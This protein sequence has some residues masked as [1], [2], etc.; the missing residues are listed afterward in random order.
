[1]SYSVIPWRNGLTVHF[2]VRPFLLTSMQV[3]VRIYVVVYK[4]NV[5]E[6]IN[7]QL[8]EDLYERNRYAGPQE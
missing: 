3:C 6:N 8:M 4:K 7:I 1:M 2:A 5:C